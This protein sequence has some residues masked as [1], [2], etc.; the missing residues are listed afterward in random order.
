MKGQ[1]L[2]IFDNIKTALFL[3]VLTFGVILIAPFVVLAL[4]LLVV[5]EA[6]QD[7][8]WKRKLRKV[9]A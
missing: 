4:C 9:K 6:I 2:N 3:I 8:R 5:V 1:R 7:Y